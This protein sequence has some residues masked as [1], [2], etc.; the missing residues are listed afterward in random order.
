MASTSCAKAALSSETVNELACSK[1][2]MIVFKVCADRVSVTI[3]SSPFYR[4]SQL[5][6][7][8]WVGSPGNWTY[9]A[10]ALEKKDAALPARV[11]L[12]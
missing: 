4:Y 8:K 10:A 1:S 2:S 6:W 11:E 12:A 3:R 5:I 9:M 7:Q